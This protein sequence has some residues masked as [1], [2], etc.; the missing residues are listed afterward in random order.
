[1]EMDRR[2]SQ[3][4]RAEEIARQGRE[5][6]SA[7]LGVR[8][9]AANADRVVSGLL[10]VQVADRRP[11]FIS[12]LVP[13]RNTRDFSTVGKLNDNG[14]QV[15]ALWAQEQDRN[16]RTKSTLLIHNLGPSGKIYEVTSYSGQSL[17]ETVTEKNGILIYCKREG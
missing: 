10:S 6:E 7:L 3:H 17:Q 1:M 4:T 14:T 15:E 12:R 9:G 13:R 8:S 5:L 2:A 11:R 16:G